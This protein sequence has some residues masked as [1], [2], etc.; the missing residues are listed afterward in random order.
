M[1]QIDNEKGFS[2]IEILLVLVVVAL[3]G[4]VG[5]TAYKNYHRATTAST[6]T[7]IATK[8]KASASTQPSNPYAGWRTYSSPD[9][10]YSVSYPSD[11]VAAN[12]S[13]GCSPTSNEI[14][15]FLSPASNSNAVVTLSHNQNSLS[16][17]AWFKQ[18]WGPT[19][20]YDTS[21]SPI[22][23][24]Q[25]YF[26]EYLINANNSSCP[27]SPLSAGAT[28]TFGM[29]SGIGYNAE[30]VVAYNSQVVTISL[31]V[32]DGTQGTEDTLPLV[33]TFKE[34]AESIKFNH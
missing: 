6:A 24:Y 10:V 8:P 25:A 32:A 5:Y 29:S 33:S 26:A 2:A 23:G 13:G 19:C 17:Q 1:K 20:S 15:D 4:V 3:I 27:R 28:Y 30:Y 34:I 7:T 14:D 18:T 11:W 31:P 9:G 21:S 12:C 16:A 22:N